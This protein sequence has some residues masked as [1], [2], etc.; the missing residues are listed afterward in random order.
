VQS[1]NI[2]GGA[3]LP[4]GYDGR[5]NGDVLVQDLNDQD[6]RG[7][8]FNPIPS[9]IH[10]FNSGQIFGEW[11]IGFSDHVEVGAGVSFYSRGVHAYYRDYE[12]QLT[13]GGDIEQNLDL[14]VI[15]I[16]AVVRFLAGR[17]GTFQPYFGVG[18]AAL[19][20]RYT[21][22]GDFID[23][24]QLT[25]TGAFVIYPARYV[26][27]GTAVGGLVLAGFRAPIKGDVWALTTEWRYQSGS[28]TTGGAPNGFLGDRIDLSGNHISFGLLVRF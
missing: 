6:F 10:R 13:G 8:E 25:N 14:R 1:L 24:T 26:T 4:R 3:F 11:L 23:F 16:T 17:P 20:Y 7:C 21:E 12:N 9:C 18:V 15:P 19:N 2:G 28:G 22:S 27:S 5:V